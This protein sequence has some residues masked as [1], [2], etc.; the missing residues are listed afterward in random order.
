MGQAVSEQALA[1]SLYNARF[2]I[3]GLAPLADAICFTRAI[4]VI[5]CAF[6]LS[7]A[8]NYF[9]FDKS[10]ILGLRTVSSLAIAEIGIGMLFIFQAIWCAFRAEGPLQMQMWMWRIVAINRL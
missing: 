3:L 7:E 6:V 1:S 5:D 4:I 8:W 10:S 2:C 9:T